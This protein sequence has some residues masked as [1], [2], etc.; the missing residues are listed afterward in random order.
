MRQERTSQ[1]CPVH[2]PASETF[3]LEARTSSRGC[4]A[5]LP[6]RAAQATLG[7]IMSREWELQIRV[8][9]DRAIRAREQGNEGL[10]RV[11]ARR[12]AGRALAAYVEKFPRPGWGS[13]ALDRLRGLEQDTQAPEG[14][15]RAAMRLTAR[16][17]EDHIL[18]FADDPLEDARLIIGHVRRLLDLWEC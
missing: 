12:A 14:V 5:L 3:G 4:P 16:V 2:R 18:P 10:A 1:I 13:S 9:L 11:C 15:R 17:T 7:E 8:E 6:G